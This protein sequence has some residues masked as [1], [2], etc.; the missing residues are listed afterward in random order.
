MKKADINY[1]YTF[2]STFG[3]VGVF[4]LFG[5]TL[6]VLLKAFPFPLMASSYNHIQVVV[7]LILQFLAVLLQVNMPY[8]PVPLLRFCAARAGIPR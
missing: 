8:A 7:P 1:T 3:E 2:G 4:S 6:V 5:G